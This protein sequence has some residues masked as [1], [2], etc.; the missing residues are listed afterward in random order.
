[1]VLLCRR[2]CIFAERG[3]DEY[4]KALL[5]PLYGSLEV[6]FVS[7][8]TLIRMKEAAD[9]AQDRIDIEH[10]RMRQKDDG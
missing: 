5:K 9:R 6:R 4:Q 2:I 3:K 7:I 8:A 10:L 1:M